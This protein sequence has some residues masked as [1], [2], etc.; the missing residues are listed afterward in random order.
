VSLGALVT[1]LGHGAV[2][3][4]LGGGDGE[5]APVADFPATIRIP[6][7]A[8]LFSVRIPCAQSLFTI[9]IPMST[10]RLH[11][12]DTL[13]LP[14]IEIR[15][16]RTG[17]LADPD[18]LTVV[19][20]PPVGAKF[21]LVY[22]TAPDDGAED[23]IIRTAAGTFTVQVAITSARGVGPYEFSIVTTGARAAEDGSFRVLPRIM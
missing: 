12:G 20:D 9:T 10:T 14:G 23:A 16:A 3:W 7:A 6:A 21:S 8:S 4:G 22:G 2:S 18:T 17:E 19:V 15:D 1:G 5:D 13:Y 11:I